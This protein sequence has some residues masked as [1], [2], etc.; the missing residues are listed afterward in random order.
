[1]LPDFMAESDSALVVAAAGQQSVIRDVWLVFHTD[2]KGSAA[3][4]AVV[5]SIREEFITPF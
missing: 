5:K 4:R 3:I 1:M 2:M